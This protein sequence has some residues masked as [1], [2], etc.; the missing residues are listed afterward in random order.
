MIIG[1]ILAVSVG[2]A[3]AIAIVPVVPAIIEE[4]GRWH[5]YRRNK[6]S[7]ELLET[8]LFGFGPEGIDDVNKAAK[9]INETN[10]DA[11]KCADIFAKIPSSSKSKSE[12]GEKMSD[13]IQE[14]NLLVGE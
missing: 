4:I 9:I 2:L 14:A 12:K 10:L 8:L 5:R 6:V 13:E 7:D 1:E 11:S 3:I